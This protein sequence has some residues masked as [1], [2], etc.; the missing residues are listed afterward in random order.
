[1]KSKKIPSFSSKLI[2]KLKKEPILFNDFLEE[3]SKNGE[4]FFDSP[5]L[6]FELLI[7]N[8]LPLEIEEDRVYL[9]T[10]K[11]LIDEQTFCIVDIETNGSNVNKGHQIIEIGAVKYKNG[12]IIDSFESLV[13]AKNIPENI[14]EITNITPKMLENAP[15]IEKVLKEFKLFLEDDV[16]VAHDIKFDYNFISSSFNKYD[17][18]KLENRKLCTIDLARR[19]IKA[20]KYG[21]SFLK[22]L[23]N[24]DI[25]NHHRAYSDALSTT[26]ILQESLKS[27]DESVKTVEDLIDFSKNAKPVMPKLEVN[28]G[29]KKE[30]KEEETN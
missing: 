7:T 5:E 20:E 28:T 14:Q 25:K 15:V 8:G 27:L 2:T 21:L 9:K 6:E 22:E 19:T 1:M 18:G 23:L 30:S 16:F 29:A 17:L 26:Y 24:I 3:I 10:S 13:Y 4:R 12:K 11:T